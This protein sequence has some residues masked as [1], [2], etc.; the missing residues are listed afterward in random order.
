MNFRVYIFSIVLLLANFSYA[1]SVSCSSKL[2]ETVALDADLIETSGAIQ[3]TIKK[4]QVIN[5]NGTRLN[6][7]PAQLETLLKPAIG[8]AKA[9][10]ITFLD[11][12]IFEFIFGRINLFGAPSYGED[13]FTGLVLP[14]ARLLTTAS[15]PISPAY[16]TFSSANGDY[17]VKSSCILN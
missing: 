16:L 15:G 9:P 2:G 13:E 7:G 11:R 1:R 3:I 10:A 17:R 6:L 4:I 12:M 8:K 5:E 14:Y